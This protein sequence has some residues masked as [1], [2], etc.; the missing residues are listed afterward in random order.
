[1]QMN[2]RII[3][4]VLLVA[5]FAAGCK[6]TD[7]ALPPHTGGTEQPDPA[8]Q[9][10]PDA[11]TDGRAFV[12]DMEALPEIHVEVAPEEWNRLLAAYDA[13][14]NTDIYIE[15]NASFVKGD[16][17]FDFE[18]A[19]LRLKG[20]TSRRRPEGWQ[21]R[22]HVK[23]D[24]DWHHCH[25]VLNFHKF[26]KDEAHEIGG[27]RK[28]HLKWFKDDACYARE[29]YCYDLFR[30]YGIPTALASSYTRLWI[31]VTGDSEEAY[32]GVYAMLETVDDEYLKARK[33]FFGDRKQ[34]L[35]KCTYGADLQST[36]DGM[37]CTDEEAGTTPYPYVLKTNTANFEAAKAQLQDFILKLNGKS[38]ESF[39]K[40]IA[41]VTDVS[42]LLRTYAVNVVVGM[43]DDYWCNKNNYY[44]YFN[45]SDLY[46]YRFF[47]IP[48][49][50]D[51]TL[52]TSSII[53]SARQ[54]PLQWGDPNRKLISKLLEYED[55]RKIYLDA[56]RELCSDDSLA[57]ADGSIARIK[58]W[59]EFVAAYVENDTGEDMS[60]EDRPASWGNHAE[61]RVTEDGQNNFFRLKAA[62]IPQQ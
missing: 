42:L 19:G 6:K 10:D 59:Q 61:Y 28:I 31:K 36:D 62:S 18:R 34:N 40:W 51:N 30:R 48:Y 1:M 26:V 49:D 60:V 7:D 47:F 11:I 2:R 13:D 14:P 8:P 37:F 32:F 21:G 16:R 38:G 43:W 3:F 39:R 24:T 17:R 15:C 45:S 35:W 58:A 22:A 29:I 12:F 55:W 9:P 23:D 54:N 33:E 4:L 53:D 20:N 57:G 5:M 44:I 46:D 27:V 25:F 52:G 41:A 50:Y 56:L